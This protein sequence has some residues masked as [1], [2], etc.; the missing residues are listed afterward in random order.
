MIIALLSKE[1]YLK[2]LMNVA[3]MHQSV[4]KR[5]SFYTGQHVVAICVVRIYKVCIQQGMHAL[6]THHPPRW[7]LLQ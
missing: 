3:L 5:V 1:H 4:S 6:C 7:C 2:L